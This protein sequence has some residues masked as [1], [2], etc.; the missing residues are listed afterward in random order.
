MAAVIIAKSGTKVLVGNNNRWVIED[1]SSPKFQA[2]YRPFQWTGADTLEKARAIFSSR[3]AKLREDKELS[4]FP[5]IHYGTP[6][7]KGFGDGKEYRAHLV[8]RTSSNGFPKG[9][10]E[11][12]ELPIVAAKREFAEEVGIDRPLEDF[13]Q[14]KT[15]NVFVLTFADTEEA[16]AE[17]IASWK[18]M[19]DR[20]EGEL[21]DLRWVDMDKL[22][23]INTDSHNAWQVYKGK[24]GRRRTRRARR[25]FTSRNL[26]L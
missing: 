16:R 8:Y 3:V 20:F 6:V 5:D 14:V 21:Y 26:L 19:N 23:P 12:G 18:Q 25:K 2:K 22:P 10:I 13:K 7:F 11:P 15:S 17:V 4:K 1:K 9:T 24:G